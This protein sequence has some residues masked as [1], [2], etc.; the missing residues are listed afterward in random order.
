MTNGKATIPEILSYINL[1]LK[2]LE[3]RNK[4]VRLEAG[5]PVWRGQ[6]LIVSFDDIAKK[7]WLTKTYGGHVW[8]W[9]TAH[10]TWT[11]EV[12][13]EDY[14]FDAD[15]KTGY[16]NVCGIT[17]STSDVVKVALRCAWRIFECYNIYAGNKE[18]DYDE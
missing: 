14:L 5:T 18:V 1:A 16:D 12:W 7:E 4:T 2:A 6:Y 11:F 3:K 15:E 10:E 9:I 17:E 13:F 8:D